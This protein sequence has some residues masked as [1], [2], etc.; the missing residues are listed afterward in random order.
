MGEAMSDDLGPLPTIHPRH[1]PCELAKRELES[2]L[3]DL[4]AKHKLS[5]AEYVALVSGA[6]SGYAHLLVRSER[7][8]G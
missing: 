1:V 3:I 8:G 4:Q 2:F 6:V 7:K 5:A